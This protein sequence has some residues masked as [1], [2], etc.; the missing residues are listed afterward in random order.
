MTDRMAAPA[1][2]IPSEGEESLY[3][4]RKQMKRKVSAFLIVALLAAL[5][6]AQEEKPKPVKGEDLVEVPAI[7][8]G[9]CVNNLFQ[10]N[11]VIQ[12]DKPIKIWGWAEPGEEV[13]VSFAGESATAKAGEDRAWSVE[14]PAQAASSEPGEIKIEGKKETLALENVLVGDVWLCGGQSN[15]EFEIAKLVGGQLEIISANFPQIRLL[16]VPHGNGADAK[17]SFPRVH[18][19]SGWFG[20]HYK[21]GD[22]DV[23]SPETV[24]L[25][26]GIGY[27]FARRL[28]MATQV[29]IGMIDVSRGGTTVE[30]WTPRSVLEQIETKEV[31]AKL[32][33]WDRKVAEFDPKEDLKERIKKHHEWVKRMKDQGRDVPADRKEPTDLR[34]GPAM[35]QNRPGNCYAS[36]IAPVSGIS[37]KGAIWHQ[38]FNNAMQPNGHIFYYQVFPEMIKAWR[39]AFNDPGM[40]FGI[41]SLCTAGEPQ[42]LDNYVSRM[43]DEG[44]Y[45]RAVQYQTFLDLKK[46]GD[47]N[48]GFASSF[49]QRRSW[50]HPQIKIPVGERIARWALATQYGFGRQI[51]WE[52]PTYKEM[53]VED[54]RILLKGCDAVTAYNDGPMLGFAIAGKDGTFQPAKAEHLITGKD[55]RGRDQRDSKVIVLSS[56]HVKAPVHF[57]YAWGRNP[58]ANVKA[59]N[60][61]DIPFAT[62]RSDDWTIVDMY[63]GLTGKNPAEAG[64]LDRRERGELSKT[65][66][67]EDVYRRTR[68]AMK[69]LE[70]QAAKE[71]GK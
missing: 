40:P 22:W 20:R 68:D 38:G 41:I 33:E 36:M 53:V 31:K 55:G 6:L 69:F 8:E 52:P 30:T 4:R 48:I 58:L 51:K 39:A 3:N 44:T 21:R 45:I 25:F 64:Q 11:M 15:M 47:E 35:D 42:D 46:A 1:Y 19:W 5:S 67:A 66:R 34:P 59:R 14:L 18:E 63:M 65:L 56:P 50:Y 13:K 9:L 60:N 2:V 7:G 70:E 24:P 71:G 57:R 29:P 32:E 27:V 43:E 23:C 61:D 17:K 54:G 16:T 49:D 28:H 37:A 12:R 62:Q 26:S 10:S